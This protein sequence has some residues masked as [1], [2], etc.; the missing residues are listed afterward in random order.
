MQQL[1]NRTVKEV[2]DTAALDANDVKLAVYCHLHSSL[3]A[4][5]PPLRLPP[6]IDRR[7]SEY[8]F[9]SL[10]ESISSGKKFTQLKSKKFG[11]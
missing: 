9:S 3:E 1:D 10:K 2:T 4:Q 6:E 11:K 5:N 8:A 7:L